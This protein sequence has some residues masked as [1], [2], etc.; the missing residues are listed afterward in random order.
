M[1][2][3]NAMHSSSRQ[4]RSPLQVTA[5]ARTRLGGRRR[6]STGG[7]SRRTWTWAGCGSRLDVAIR[8]VVDR[9]QLVVIRPALA[10]TSHEIARPDHDVVEAVL[11]V[12]LGVNRPSPA[13]A[14]G[15]AV[16][17]AQPT[18][19]V[20]A[21]GRPG[22]PLSGHGSQGYATSVSVEAAMLAAC[23]ERWSASRSRLR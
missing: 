22:A 3:L 10:D 12:R 18:E 1:P 23:V 14:I 21:E 5:M 16:A 8:S 17:S 11:L 9:Q 13:T 7:L 19:R 4:T 20:A 15:D 6:R 2:G